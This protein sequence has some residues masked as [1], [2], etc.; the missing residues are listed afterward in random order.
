VTISSRRHSIDQ[1]AG[2]QVPPGAVL[3]NWAA[4]VALWALPYLALLD[5]L[6]L[7]AAQSEIL[8][9]TLVAVGACGLASV[10]FTAWRR[11][12]DPAWRARRG[13]KTRSR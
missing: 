1:G 11:T 6:R 8:Q 9:W 2:A 12:R 10:F 3:V 13:L 7:D 4:L 5:Y